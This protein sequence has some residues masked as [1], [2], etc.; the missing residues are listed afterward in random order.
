MLAIVK[1]SATRAGRD[2]GP[3]RLL[4]SGRGGV[5]APQGGWLETP[6]PR[7]SEAAF[8]NLHCDWSAA[9]ALPH[10]RG[11]KNEKADEAAASGLLR[12]SYVHSW[13]TGARLASLDDAVPAWICCSAARWSAFLFGHASL[14]EIWALLERRSLVAAGTLRAAWL[15]EGAAV[16][17]GRSTS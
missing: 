13:A 10:A 3:S 1:P 11:P 4:A 9:G 6:S 8:W 16:Y 17:A 2:R 5:G 7:L 14:P 15:A 12:Y